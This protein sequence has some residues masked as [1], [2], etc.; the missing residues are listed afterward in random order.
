MQMFHSAHIIFLMFAC[1]RTGALNYID[2]VH[3]EPTIDNIN[4]RTSGL[5]SKQLPSP[6]SKITRASPPPN[7]LQ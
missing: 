1:V 3:W 6:L 5:I 4:L 2:T 7:Q